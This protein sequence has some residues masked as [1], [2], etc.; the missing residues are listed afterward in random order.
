MATADALFGWDFERA[1]LAEWAPRLKWIQVQ[2]AGVNH[3]LPFDWIPPG[4]TLT[5]CRGAHGRRASEY[6]IMAILA[7]IDPGTHSIKVVQGQ[8]AGPV[9]K[10]LRAIENREFQ[11]VGE[12]RTRQADVRLVAMTNE[13]LEERVAQGEFR[14]DLY[15]RLNVFPI[16]LPRLRACLAEKLGFCRLP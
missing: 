6:L 16:R 5:N 15:Y 12:S 13:Q 11:V 1:H 7:G 14:E 4:I 8:M 10:L 9:F 3:L 2:G